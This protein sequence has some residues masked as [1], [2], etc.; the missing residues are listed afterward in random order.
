[1]FRPL[2]HVVNTHAQPRA[3]EF[4]VIAPHENPG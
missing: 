3:I 1:M 4:G 2:A